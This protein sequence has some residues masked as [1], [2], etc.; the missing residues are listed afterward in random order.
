M[1]SGSS[2]RVWIEDEG[3]KNFHLATFWDARSE[4]A[5]QT[6]DNISAQDLFLNRI[7]DNPPGSRSTAEV[8]IEGSTKTINVPIKKLRRFYD[9]PCDAEIR[10]NRTIDLLATATNLPSLLESLRSLVERG[11]F[12]V[13]IGPVFVNLR[14]IVA[15][16]NDEGQVQRMTAIALETLAS[17]NCASIVLSGCSGS[18]K[19]WS[20][21]LN[22]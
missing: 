20:D 8:E 22:E 1:E 15:S 10:S 16:A 19:R 13:R 2:V 4:Q 21:L 7:I 5:V 12:V 18:G 14:P 9:P 6:S 17:G 3:S 11:V